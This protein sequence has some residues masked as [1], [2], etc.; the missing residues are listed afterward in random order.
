M[1]QVTLEMI[2][3]EIVKIANSY[4][5]IENE[6]FNLRHDIKNMPLATAPAKKEEKKKTPKFSSP[7]YP[8]NK[9]V[10]GFMNYIKDTRDASKVEFQAK[11]K[12]K[13]AIGQRDNKEKLYWVDE[14]GVK[15]TLQQEMAAKWEALSELEKKKYNDKFTADKVKYDQLIKDWEKAYPLEFKDYQDFIAK[16][17]KDK[18]AKASKKK[19]KIDTAVKN[20][21][22]Q[23]EVNTDM[24]KP[25]AQ[26][27]KPIQPVQKD[28]VNV[29]STPSSKQILQKLNLNK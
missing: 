13:L 28:E 7:H 22:Y 19:S 6:L 15:H 27:T 21:Q 9:P 3:A 17:G 20:I 1:S 5:Q 23:K 12:G 29:Q 25:T 4:K 10:N 2:M 14:K 26:E 11:Y 18:P 8:K 24:T 16:L